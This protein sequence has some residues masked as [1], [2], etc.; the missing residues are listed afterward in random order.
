MQSSSPKV[1]N[2]FSQQPSIIPLPMSISLA[3]VL[4]ENIN[5]NID[6][7]APVKVQTALPPG[8]RDCRFYFLFSKKGKGRSLFFILFLV[9]AG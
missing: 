4:F 9:V 3:R 8:C 5:V 6:D 1:N 2:F 7:R